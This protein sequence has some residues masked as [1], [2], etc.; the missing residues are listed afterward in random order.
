VGTELEGRGT[1][2]P[3]KDTTT[4]INQSCR[5]ALRIDICGGQS[6]WDFTPN[7][8]RMAKEASPGKDQKKKEE[9]HICLFFLLFN[10]KY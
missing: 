1:S 9:R 6:V 8:W 7:S 5:S 10:K 2:L 3:R 4:S